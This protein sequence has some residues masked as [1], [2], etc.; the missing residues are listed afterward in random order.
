MTHTFASDN[1]AGVHPEIMDALRHANQA[2]SSSYGADPYTGR[3]LKKFHEHFGDDIKVFFAY[4]GT[5]ANVLGLSALTRSFESIICSDLAHINVDESTAPEKFTGCKLLTI[6]TKDGKI[7]PAEI[8]DRIHRVG[9]QHH[10]QVRVIS[11]SQSTEYATVYTAEEIKAIS[12]VKAS[13][14]PVVHPIRIHGGIE[15]E[16]D[17]R[18]MWLWV[19]ADGRMLTEEEIAVESG[20]TVSGSMVRGV[21]RLT[22]SGVMYGGADQ[23][24]M[25][26]RGA[27]VFAENLPKVTPEVSNRED[28]AVMDAGVSKDPLATPALR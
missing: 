19:T 10:P 7:Y 9:D 3:A 28:V 24:A 18:P 27:S 1:Y 12:E 6:T 8:E 20:G 5:G 13:S 16:R 17:G 15:S 4:N 2:H 21:R 14:T 11:I 22:G 25:P 26:V 23:D